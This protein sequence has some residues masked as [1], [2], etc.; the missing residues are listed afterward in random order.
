[1]WYNY[2]IS[3]VVRKRRVTG[4][5]KLKQ[6][7]FKIRDEIREFVNLYDNKQVAIYGAGHQS[8]AVI[9]LAEIGDKVKYVVDDATFKQDKYTPATHVPIVSKE[10]LIL[11]PPSAIIIM[12]ASY[13]DEVAK[14]ISK[15]DK[16]TGNVVILRDFGLE[17]VFL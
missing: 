1:M 3:A 13:S 17:K 2:I 5:N 14:K 6:H 8:L 15:D 11:D 4:L 12:A 10:S 7:Q 9:S 16:I